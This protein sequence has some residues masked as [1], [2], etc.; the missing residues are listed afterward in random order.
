MHERQYLITET[1]LVSLVEQVK[2]STAN[3]SVDEMLLEDQ[4]TLDVFFDDPH[5]EHVASM[6]SFPQWSPSD[7]E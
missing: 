2:Q 5:S 3:V 4:A 6:F 1:Q 7:D